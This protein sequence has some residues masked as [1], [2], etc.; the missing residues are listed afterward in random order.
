MNRV[1]AADDD[2]ARPKRVGCNAVIGMRYDPASVMN[3]ANEV[4]R[5]GAAVVVEPEGE[6][7]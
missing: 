4:L 6:A 5:Y 1:H 7:P 2:E 3:E